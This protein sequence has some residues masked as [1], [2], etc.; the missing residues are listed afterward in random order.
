MSTEPML[1]WRDLG[2]QRLRWKRGA[3]ED[4]LSY[5]L[6]RH[7][8][9]GWGLFVVSAIGVLVTLI[10][11]ATLVASP[12][13]GFH[14]KLWFVSLMILFAI[15]RVATVSSRGTRT[16]LLAATVFPEW[17]YDLFLQGVQI[18]ALAAAVWRTKKHW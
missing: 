11:I 8:L 1:T 5:G 2:R 9:K 7:T 10:Y 6:T 13:L 16:Q 4:L 12:W 17:F 14:P 3:F 18:R 15:E